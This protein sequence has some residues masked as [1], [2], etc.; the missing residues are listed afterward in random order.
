[1]RWSLTG[2]LSGSESKLD[3]NSKNFL[4]VYLVSGKEFDKFSPAVESHH[5]QIG[6]SSG[7]FP[8][9]PARAHRISSRV[10]VRSAAN[11]N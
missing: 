7:E 5:S 2:Q 11:E 4:I 6:V 3:E 10:D 8:M 9:N 1:M